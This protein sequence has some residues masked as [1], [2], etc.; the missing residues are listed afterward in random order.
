MPVINGPELYEKVRKKYVK[1]NIPFFFISSLQED[2][3]L[4]II[5]T[6]QSGFFFKKPLEKERLT[7]AISE[8]AVKYLG[9]K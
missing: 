3:A 9:N 7:Q 1:E 5:D 6:F 2:E 4:N 8:A